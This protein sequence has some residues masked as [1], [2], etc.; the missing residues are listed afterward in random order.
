MAFSPLLLNDK[1][2][3]RKNSSEEYWTELQDDLD[4]MQ[5]D[6]PVNLVHPVQINMRGF[7]KRFTLIRT[8]KREAEEF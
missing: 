3:T 2:K 5:G 4:L 1:P 6:Y 8:S 7:Q